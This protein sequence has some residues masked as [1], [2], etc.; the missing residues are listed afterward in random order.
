MRS[1][2][3][4]IG[5]ATTGWDIHTFTQ[6]EIKRHGKMCVAVHKDSYPT[7]LLRK[8][9]LSG[10]HPVSAAIAPYSARNLHCASQN[11]KQGHSTSPK[12]S[13]QS[14]TQIDWHRPELCVIGLA[15]NSKRHCGSMPL[16]SV[17]IHLL[18][19]D[20][21]WQCSEMP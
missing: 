14:T 5:Q 1:F 16:Y 8:I 20:K 9:P 4:I 13:N 15:S 17:G 19:P 11:K 12:N 7:Q 3:I 6:P 2:H 21:S 10:A 18:E